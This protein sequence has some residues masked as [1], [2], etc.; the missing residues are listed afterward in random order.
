MTA[1]IATLADALAPHVEHLATLQAQR[2]A[3][4]AEME[5]VKAQIRDIVATFGPGT[6]GTDKGAVTVSLNRRLDI[7]AIARDYPAAIRPDLYKLTP[8]P[9]AVRK[10]LPPVIVEEYMVEQGEPR[11]TVKAVQP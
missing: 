5:A 4:D 9:A 7:A 10:V 3:I 1:N 6:Y 2:A 8:D 11:V